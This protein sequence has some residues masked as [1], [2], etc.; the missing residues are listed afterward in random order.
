MFVKLFEV[1]FI[2]LMWS[3]LFFKVCFFR[4]VLV[5]VVCT[6]RLNWLRVFLSFQVVVGCFVLFY[7]CRLLT[8]LDLF[9]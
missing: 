9:V 8:F 1:V 5:L 4:L 3:S 2:L 6:C 7:V